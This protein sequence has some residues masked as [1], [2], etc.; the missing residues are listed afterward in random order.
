MQY[1]AV[2]VL[3]NDVSS[4]FTPYAN[5][6]ALTNDL[7]FA[8]VMYYNIENAFYLLNGNID[9]SKQKNQFYQYHVGIDATEKMVI[10]VNRTPNLSH[11]LKF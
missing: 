5:I 7:W 11:W 6:K 8:F 2:C 10:L 3:L 4:G 9:N 1:Q